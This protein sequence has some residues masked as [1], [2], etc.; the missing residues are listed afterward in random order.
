MNEEKKRSKWLLIL[1]I[2]IIMI[3][4]IALVMVAKTSENKTNGTS[5]K[6]SVGKVLVD[7][8][9]TRDTKTEKVEGWNTYLYP[10]NITSP[11][12]DP[13]K[14]IALQ[15]SYSL[16]K[17]ANKTETGSV[18]YRIE[19]ATRQD[20]PRETKKV[21]EVCDENNKTVQFGSTKDTNITGASEHVQASVGS[22]AS[23]STPN[24]AGNYRVDAFIF[25]NGKWT[26]TDRIDSIK[27]V[28]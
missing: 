5:S 18:Y 8:T 1:I 21:I 4:V 25:T 23:Y 19:L 12:P 9:A 7:C 6:A 13:D 24:K 11:M 14:K 20:L 27:I 16:S 17:W 15:E 3:V 26:L 22:L 10:A 2:F 28:D